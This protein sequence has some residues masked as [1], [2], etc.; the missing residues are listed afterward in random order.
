M[1]GADAVVEQRADVADCI[2]EARRRHQIPAGAAAGGHERRGPER[3]DQ[4]QDV[5]DRID[6]VPGHGDGV[7]ADR[8]LDE[9]ERE[10]R[11]RRC[12]GQRHD[13][14]VEIVG[15]GELPHLLAHQHHHADVCQREKA[16]PQVVGEDGGGRIGVVEALV[17]H[18]E[19]AERPQAHPGA[20]REAEAAILG[21]DHRSART[22]RLANNSNE[23][24]PQPS[25]QVVLAPLAR[26]TSEIA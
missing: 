5:A 23:A 6:Q 22:S 20:E 8:L 4:E 11:E 2:G 1:S 7:I 26:T 17:G 18:R 21:A 10:R 14:A 12:A 16:D 3:Q 13:D 25:S 24:T 9:P 15:G 19:V